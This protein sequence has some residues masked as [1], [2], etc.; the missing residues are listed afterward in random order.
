MFILGFLAEVV[1]V[2]IGFSSVLLVQISESLGS[3]DTCAWASTSASPKIVLITVSI[4][5][6]FRCESLSSAFGQGLC[7]TTVKV[8]VLHE[9]WAP[10]SLQLLQEQVAH[11]IAPAW[12]EFMIIVVFDTFLRGNA[13]QHS[14]HVRCQTE[15][16]RTLSISANAAI[17]LNVLVE[18]L[19]VALEILGCIHIASAMPFAIGPQ[20]IVQNYS[21]LSSS[22]PWQFLKLF[23]PKVLE[24]QRKRRLVHSTSYSGRRRDFFYF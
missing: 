10:L 20:N 2:F 4:D 7:T 13:Y 19:N 18:V 22:S 24:A 14:R 12:Y 5:K 17:L 16:D 6:I 21:T 23:I 15:R 11:A 8:T 9:D 1:N 3:I